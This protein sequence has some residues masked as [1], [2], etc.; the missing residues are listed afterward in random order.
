MSEW[1]YVGYIRLKKIHYLNEL[2]QLFF[3]MQPL[4]YVHEDSMLLLQDGVAQ[5]VP[6]PGRSGAR[7]GGSHQRLLPPVLGAEGTLPGRALRV[8][9]QGPY[10]VPSIL[11]TCTQVSLPQFMEMKGKRLWKAQ[12]VVGKQVQTTDPHPSAYLCLTCLWTEVSTPPSNTDSPISGV[13]SMIFS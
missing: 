4:E 3:P 8:F 6:A 2:H 10:M 1:S 13:S 5:P 9:C 12:Q 7:V 11:P